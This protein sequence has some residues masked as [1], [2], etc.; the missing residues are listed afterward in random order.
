MNARFRREKRGDGDAKPCGKLGV[1]HRQPAE[2]RGN[3]QAGFR[4]QTRIVVVAEQIG[5][6]DQRRHD[7]GDGREK[8]HGADVD[9][10]GSSQAEKCE[11]SDAG[12]PAGRPL[13][14]TAF[15]LKTDQQPE[16]QRYR[17]IEPY[18]VCHFAILTNVCSR[19]KV[20]VPTVPSGER[21]TRSA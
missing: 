16:A 7:G 2:K 21:C 14:L 12:R 18:R 11:G 20:D 10:E 9:S 8:H 5:H 6:R 17:E 3:H 19:P 13:A 1:R 15:P 4:G